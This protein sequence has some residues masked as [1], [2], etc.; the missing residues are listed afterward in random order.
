MDAIWDVG[1]VGTGL[2]VASGAVRGQSGIVSDVLCPVVVGR[3]KELRALAA[4]LADA[5]GGRG[6]CS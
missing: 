4:D 6:R 3:K 1:L 5:L 2:I